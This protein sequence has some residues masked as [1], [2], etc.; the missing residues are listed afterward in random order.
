M[1]HWCPTKHEPA[2]VPPI[3]IATTLVQARVV[4]IYPLARSKEKLNFVTRWRSRVKIDVDYIPQER[5]CSTSCSRAMWLRLA[6]LSHYFSLSYTVYSESEVSSWWAAK[7][8]VVRKLKHQTLE[9]F[10]AHC[11]YHS[12][13]G[14]RPLTTSYAWRRFDTNWGGGARDGFHPIVQYNFSCYKLYNQ[15]TSQLDVVMS[16]CLCT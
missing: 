15:N 10:L 11:A 4:G 14:N 16:P 12:G 13:L 6:L 3:H 9:P 1:M 8:S 7:I 5:S 2:L